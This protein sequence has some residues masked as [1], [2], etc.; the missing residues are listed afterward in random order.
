[1]ENAAF[2]GYYDA[3]MLLKNRRLGA[4]SCVL[5]HVRLNNLLLQCIV[6]IL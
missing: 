2:W 4:I 3:V 6:A 5:S 1:M